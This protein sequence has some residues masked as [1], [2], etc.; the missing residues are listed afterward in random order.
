MKITVPIASRGRPAGLLSVLTS[1]DA[2]ATGRNEIVY[3]LIL[4]DDD[5]VTLDHLSRWEADNLLPAGVVPLIGKRDKTLNARMNEAMKAFPAEIYSV[6]PDDG[7]PLAQHWDEMYTVL[8]RNHA[9]PSFAWCEKNDPENATFI[10][11]S[12]RWVSAVGGFP[13]YFPF[14]F[15]DTWIL[16]VHA[17]AFAK[18]I[19]VVNQL[20]MGGKR[21]KTQGMRD[22]E[23]WFKF[24]TQTRQERVGQ[25]E[26][27]AR[28]YGF[29]VDVRKERKEQL[30]DFD[31][32][33]AW[34]LTQVARYETMFKAV[35]EPT[36]MY[37]QVKAAAEAW[38]QKL[39]LAA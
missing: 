12:D 35:E 16:E 18:P 25:A 4:D 29:T 30:A 38:M 33:D 7:F 31:R 5:F 1:M 13:E 24:F 32:R 11:L 37:K 17:L 19:A 9:M 36:E 14:W 8:I 28:S 21:G 2:L 3:P 10:V 20:S 39:E 15:A 22:L 34:Q 23:F 6:L 27:L 26:K